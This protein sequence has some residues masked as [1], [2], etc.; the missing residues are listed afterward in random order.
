MLNYLLNYLFHSTL[1]I[2][3]VLILG[4]FKL[5]KSQYLQDS[6][7]KLALVGAFFSAGLVQLQATSPV[8]ITKSNINLS[9]SYFEHEAEVIAN[10]PAPIVGSI[11]TAQSI[12]NE[13][14]EYPEQSS[15]PKSNSKYWLNKFNFAQIIIGLYFVILGFLLLRIIRAGLELKQILKHKKSLANSE[16]MQILENLKEKANYY[17]TVKLTYSAKLLSPIAMINNEICLP[18]KV[19]SLSPQEQ[20]NI[21]A[22]ELGH[23][24]RNDPYWL[25][26]A[27]FIKT[28]F[29]F[30]V[31]N[32]LNSK[33]LIDSAEYICD[34]FALEQTQD[35]IAL[36]KSL[37]TVAQWQLKPQ[38]LALVNNMA[39]SSLRQRIKQVLSGN[40]LEPSSKLKKLALSTI[41]ILL[42]IVFVPKLS[43]YAQSPSS[44]IQTL[45][46]NHPEIKQIWIAT[47]A[48]QKATF[49]ENYQE[50]ISLPKGSVMLIEEITANNSRKIALVGTNSGIDYRYSENGVSK[51]F[52]SNIDNWYKKLIKDYANSYYSPYRKIQHNPYKIFSQ[53]YSFE[54]GHHYGFSGKMPDGQIITPSTVY[55]Y[56]HIDNVKNEINKRKG[57]LDDVVGP[58]INA[59]LFSNYDDQKLKQAVEKDVD[60][61]NNDYIVMTR[62]GMPMV[63][64]DIISQTSETRHIR[65]EKEA[66]RLATQALKE[67]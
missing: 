63:L 39:A 46:N 10:N 4:H 62:L 1:I 66:T 19:L 58:F 22:H 33:A 11:E 60:Q 50:L 49:S 25:L 14:A 21:L 67:N 12:I 31:L 8:V 30:Q 28:V 16:L 56:S 59:K 47:I 35:S 51:P 55:F 3:T 40:R 24:I 64:R 6:L 54:R 2:S 20:E 57:F 44:D 17:Q 41:L 65:L 27:T 7:L 5:I 34:D 61:T 43:I 37:A 32:S 53:G 15:E 42:V 36:A 13:P 29:F 9:Q 52:D 18:E 38:S 23:I 26:L 48:M 45:S